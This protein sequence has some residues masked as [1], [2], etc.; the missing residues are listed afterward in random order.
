MHYKDGTPA[1][2][3]DQI[4][5]KPYNTDHEIVGI[6]TSITPGADSCNCKVAFVEVKNL[7][8][9]IIG[10]QGILSCD[11]SKSTPENPIGEKKLIILREDY[12]QCSDFLKVV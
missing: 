5:G 8:E 4:K 10:S 6:M 12:G 1:A 9:V 2:V 3:G 7:D 11:L